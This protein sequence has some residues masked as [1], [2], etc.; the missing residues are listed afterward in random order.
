M[1]SL[2]FILAQFAHFSALFIEGGALVGMT[3][4]GLGVYGFYRQTLYPQN[5][6]TAG[7][8]AKVLTGSAL[9]IS[10]SIFQ[11]FENTFF[12]TTTD[13][14]SGSLHL[15]VDALS[16]LVENGV[17]TGSSSIS[18][19]LIPPRSS[20]L[21]VGFMY[22]IG[23]LAFLKGIFVL[24]DAGEIGNQQNPSPVKTS[25]VYMV[26]GVIAVNINDFGCLFGSTFG[27]TLFCAVNS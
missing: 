26:S 23:V 19:Q 15:N 13:L 2:T 22:M 20:A 7:N 10:G 1:D 17:R 11:G 18:S 12:D 25:L 9:V 6:T 8:F 14:S 5:Y 16:A 21:I 4:A 24:K 3:V 27:T